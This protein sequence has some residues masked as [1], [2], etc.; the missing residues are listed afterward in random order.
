[1]I[2]FLPTDYLELLFQILK[3]EKFEN[4][5]LISQSDRKI[6]KNIFNKNP[7]VSSIGTLQMLLLNQ[8]I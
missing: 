5:K 2:L 6:N 4:L 8:Q 1:M 7:A 3:N